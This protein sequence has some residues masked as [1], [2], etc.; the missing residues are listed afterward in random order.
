MKYIKMNKYNRLIINQTI[1]VI[2]LK[3]GM[4]N[5]FPQLPDHITEIY[6]DNNDIPN[7]LYDL[8]CN[9]RILSLC[10]NLLDKLVYIPPSLQELYITNNKNIS[11]PNTLIDTNLTIFY[12]N[13]CSL[14]C[15]PTLPNTISSLNI[16]N[17]KLTQF[18]IPINIKIL[19]LANNKLSHI[20]LTQTHINLTELRCD[21]NVI[22]YINYIPNNLCEL[23]C[24]SNKIKIFPHIPTNL[25]MVLK[26][27]DTSILYPYNLKMVFS[28]W[29]NPLIYDLSNIDNIGR[30]INALNKFRIWYHTNKLILALSKYIH[31]RRMKIEQDYEFL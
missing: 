1:S 11:L 13:E 10:S 6:L 30:Y 2:N 14:T 7:I 19:N 12:C 24:S 29:N 17:N 21:N 8:P 16:S 5:S 26:I 27:M 22:R 28:F 20:Y 18:E 23:H 31:N 9:L 4:I 25:H 15:I 3:N